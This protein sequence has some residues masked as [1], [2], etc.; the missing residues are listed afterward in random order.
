MVRSSVQK[1]PSTGAAVAPPPGESTYRISCPAGARGFGYT[2][3]GA[4]A[5]HGN[6]AVTRA[7]Q[8][9]SG[10]WLVAVNVPATG[11]GTATFRPWVNCADD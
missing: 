9:S 3:R 1:L 11:P 7:D 4:A 10:E 5:D 2:I 6:I 8:L